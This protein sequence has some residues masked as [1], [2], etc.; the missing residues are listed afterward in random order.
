MSNRKEFGEGALFTISNYFWWF[1]A[2]NFYFVILNLPI[3]LLLMGLR[4][5][6]IINPTIWFIALCCIPLGPSLTALLGVMGKLVR[7]KD[8]NLT[9]DFFKA[10]KSSFKQSTLIWTIE[11]IIIALLFVDA[12]Y[13]L[14]IKS[15]LV[16]VIFILIL[17]ILLVVFYAL[18]IISRFYLRTV[19]ILKLC[20]TFSKLYLKTFLLNF[21]TLIAF[22]YIFFKIP[23]IS[24]LFLMSFYCYAL[25]YNNSNILKTIEKKIQPTI[26]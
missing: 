2:A 17:F 20:F 5:G 13:F 14:L 26:D 12:R 15:K 16:F 11:V 7:E 22:G 9:R 3:V 25:M 4:T 1:L 18:S 19:D 24:I 23:V 10:Y 6:I 8:L 21:M